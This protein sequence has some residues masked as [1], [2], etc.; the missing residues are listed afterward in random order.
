MNFRNFSLPLVAVL[1]AVGGLS[2]FWSG[3]NSGAMASSASE[4]TA[5]PV[6]KSSSSDLV[7]GKKIYKKANC[8]GCHKWHGDGGGGYGGAALSLRET[9]MDLD[10]IIEVVACGRPGTGM[11]SFHRKAYKTYNCYD[12]TMDELGEDKPPKPAKRLRDPDIARVAAYVIEKIKGQG[13]MTKAQCTDFW[14]VGAR[15]CNR[16]K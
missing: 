16:F 11:P 7:L 1:L 4:K 12:M 15:E 6:G 8:I 3:N 14:G 9:V 2:L 5:A 10:Q 13:D